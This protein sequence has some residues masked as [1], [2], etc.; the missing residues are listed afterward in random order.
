MPY[1]FTTGSV[2]SHLDLFNRLDEFIS[3]TLGWSVVHSGYEFTDRPWR[4]YHSSGESGGED[5]YVGVLCTWHDPL[6]AWLQFNGYTGVNTSSDSFVDQPGSVCCT[7]GT[8]NHVFRW[9]AS[10]RSIDD[11]TTITYWFFGDKDCFIIVTKFHYGYYGI[12]Y[13]GLPHRFWSS[14]VDQCPLLLAGSAEMGSCGWGSYST[15]GFP[16]SCAC[17]SSYYKCCHFRPVPYRANVWCSRGANSYLMCPDK[18]GWYG[19]GAGTNYRQT[20]YTAGHCDCCLWGIGSGIYLVHEPRGT[21][22]SRSDGMVLMPIYV[23]ANK[24]TRGILKHIYYTDP[25]SLPSESITYVAGDPYIIFN[26]DQAGADAK[27]AIRFY[28]D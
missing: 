9:F 24:Q 14:S 2:T 25:G 12:S 17:C 19:R 27:V 5:I 13:V 15:Y 6:V 21:H 4:I 8:G 3:G 1:K 28:E 22:S 18:S 11:G 16:L 10:H 20:I 7:P 23:V 26:K